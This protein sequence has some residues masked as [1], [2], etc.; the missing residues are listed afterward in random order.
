MIDQLRNTWRR[1]QTGDSTGGSQRGKGG[2]QVS[3]TKVGVAALDGPP[4]LSFGRVLS[5]KQS[6]KTIGYQCLMCLCV[7][8]C[9]CAGMHTLHWK[10]EPSYF[11]QPDMRM[12][13]PCSSSSMMAKHWPLVL[14]RQRKGHFLFV[15]DGSGWVHQD[16]RCC[17][18]S[19]LTGMCYWWRRRDS[20][21]N[22]SS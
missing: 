21:R 9:V 19:G 10:C 3:V 15:S 5:I 12:A 4:G 22:S 7:C 1:G 18:G 16:R 8:A 14:R 20:D 6:I 2:L 13:S 11:M 17:L